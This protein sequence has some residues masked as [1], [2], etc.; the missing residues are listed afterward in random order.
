MKKEA[1][2]KISYSNDKLY[3]DVSKILDKNTSKE[4]LN[5]L[6]N[7]VKNIKHK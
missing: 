4:N 6:K 3:K 5:F 1:E 7:L 2:Q